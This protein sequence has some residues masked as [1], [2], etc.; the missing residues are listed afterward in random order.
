M[1]RLLLV[2][3]ILSIGILV[4]VC[5]PVLQ[6][7]G[8]SKPSLKQLAIRCGKLLDGKSPN[9]VSDAVIL[10]D[11]D[12]IA[13]AGRGWPRLEDSRRRGGDRLEP[14]N[15]ASRFDRHAHTPDLS[16]RHR[17]ERE[18]GGDSDLFR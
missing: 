12:R 9:P 17:A 7:S 1:R 14:R 18:T 6:S 11:G 10:I 16:L 8:Q 3:T 15:R 5:P 13:A 4:L 2:L